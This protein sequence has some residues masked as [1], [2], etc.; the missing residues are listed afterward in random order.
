MY[1]GKY[2]SNSKAPRS[3]KA[4][5]TQK[6]KKAVTVGTVLFY[7]LY[8]LGILACAM[9]IFHGMGMLEDWLIRF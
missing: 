7:C 6:Q 2:L 1:Q 5:K 9:A 8:A 3:S 4:P